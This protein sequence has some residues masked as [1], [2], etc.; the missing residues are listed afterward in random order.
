MRSKSFSRFLRERSDVRVT[1]SLMP[2]R[3]S[4]NVSSESIKEGGKTHEDP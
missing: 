1:T 3:K 2:A 4:A